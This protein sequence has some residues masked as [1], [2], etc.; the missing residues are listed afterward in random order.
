MISETAGAVYRRGIS[1]G[2]PGLRSAG[3]ART[4]GRKKVARTLGRKKVART[5]GRKKVARTLG[6]R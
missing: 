2:G 1:F 4:L 3:V 6:R 5:L